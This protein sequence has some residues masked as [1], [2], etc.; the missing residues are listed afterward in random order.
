VT[1]AQRDAVA[2]WIGGSAG[3]ILTAQAI[4]PTDA[5][6]FCMWLVGVTLLGWSSAELFKVL[7][8]KHWSEVEDYWHDRWDDFLSDG[9]LKQPKNPRV[10]WGEMRELGGDCHY[11][12][13]HGVPREFSMYWFEMPSREYWRDDEHDRRNQEYLRE[14]AAWYDVDLNQHAAP[15]SEPMSAGAME[16]YRQLANDIDLI[17]NFVTDW[18]NGRNDDEQNETR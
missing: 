4:P 9:H 2:Y 18:A 6:S 15:Y 10:M 3:A 1:G 13:V 5:F 8:P 12:H 7:Q 17:D 14:A 11:D 16:R